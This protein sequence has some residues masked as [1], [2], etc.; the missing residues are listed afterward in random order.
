VH[1]NF[2]AQTGQKRNASPRSKAYTILKFL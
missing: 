1:S 2:E